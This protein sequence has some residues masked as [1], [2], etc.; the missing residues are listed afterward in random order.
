[1]HVGAGHCSPKN[2]W[3]PE[4]EVS[5][6]YKGINLFIGLF[7]TSFMS[8]T[9]VEVGGRREKRYRYS[10]PG[11]NG[12]VHSHHWGKAVLHRGEQRL[13]ASYEVCAGL[14]VSIMSV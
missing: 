11:S 1:M 9:V 14:R 13:R 10:P 7:R 4:K 12:L 6:V 5:F 8:V 2:I 3:M